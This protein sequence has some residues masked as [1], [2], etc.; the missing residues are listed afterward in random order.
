MDGPVQN[1]ED[2]SFLDDL[3]DSVVERLSEGDDVDPALLSAKRPH[4]AGR[5]EEI[6][7]LAAELVGSP[8][9]TRPRFAGYEILGEL[10]RGAGENVFLARQ[11]A[12]GGRQVALKVLPEGSALSSRRLDRFLAEIRALARLSHPNIVPIFDVIRTERSAAYAM[13][14]I[15]GSTLGQVISALQTERHRDG[16][17]DVP[18]IL[19]VPSEVRTELELIDWSCRVAIAVARA[20]HIVH[21]IGLVHRDVKPSNILLRRNG[22]PLLSDFGLVKDPEAT[23]RTQSGQFLGTAAYAAPEQLRGDAETVDGRS[24]IYGLGATLYHCLSRE[25]PFG[26]GSPEAIAHRV[27]SGAIRPLRTLNPK[28]GKDLCTVV[29]K[30]MDPLPVRRYETAELFADD[31]QRCVDRRPILARRPGVASRAARWVRREPAWAAL[32]FASVLV[33]AGTVGAATYFGPRLVRTWRED[34]RL[35]A[36]SHLELGCLYLFDRQFGKAVEEFDAGLEWDPADAEAFAMSVIARVR[37]GDREGA[38]ERLA[39]RPDLTAR[40]SGFQAL[41]SWISKGPARAIGP[42]PGADGPAPQRAALDSVLE[43]ICSLFSAEEGEREGYG[44]ALERFE[45]AI[46]L[47]GAR[48]YVLLALQCQA[49][50]GSGR[51][52]ILE[53]C[54]AAIES[55]W[56]SEPGALYRCGAAIR[57]AKRPAD[58]LRFFERAAELAPASAYPHNGRGNALGDLGRVDDAIVAFRRAVELDSNYVHA[59]YN[60]GNCLLRARRIEEA[61]LHLRKAVELDPEFASA[62]INLA[63]ALSGSNRPREAE[64][65]LKE[66]IRRGHDSHRIRYNLAVTLARSGDRAGAVEHFRKAVGFEPANARTQHDLG[67]CLAGLGRFDEASGPFERS[68]DLGP[69]GSEWEKDAAQWLADCERLAAASRIVTNDERAEPRALAQLAQVA[70]RRGFHVLA[71]TLH[72]KAIEPSE[73]ARAES[74]IEGARAAVAAATGRDWGASSL[75]AEARVAWLAQALRWLRDDLEDASRRVGDGTLS[76]EN[77]ALHLR[78]WLDDPALAPIRDEGAI[79]SVPDEIRERIRRLWRDVE[80]FASNRQPNAVPR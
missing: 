21:S 24:D 8:S 30:A 4:L 15:D 62:S 59:H 42:A 1:T 78:S 45:R 40:S 13:E 34:R 39:G 22:T 56:P 67:R 53:K 35:R 64:S 44:K 20:L 43:G 61:I 60:L 18:P 12:V 41:E 5:V 75:D 38:L 66:L 76:P 7:R 51:T 50:E 72:R 55:R 68:R 9:A 27:D 28:L 65:I 17:R 49:A 19:G 57:A 46:Y 63:S 23:L 29:E 10:G 6:V 70:T 11:N 25:L 36:E 37:N 58:A 31:L 3:F 2:E 32:L 54:V 48:S 52:D 73:G 79:P 47:S 80:E 71:A 77:A 69:K 26:T 16:A 14:W 74:R 33:I